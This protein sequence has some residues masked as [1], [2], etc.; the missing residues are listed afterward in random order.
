MPA[1]PAYATRT[2]SPCHPCQSQTYLTLFSLSPPH[3]TPYQILA[4]Q[5]ESSCA[6]NAIS[7]SGST[8]GRRNI[9][10]NSRT[11]GAPVTV[12]WIMVISC[13]FVG[14]CG[15]GALGALGALGN[16][17]V[18]GRLPTIGAGS[19]FSICR[20]CGA[21]FIEMMMTIFTAPLDFLSH[22]SASILSLRSDS[23][24]P[25]SKTIVGQSVL[26]GRKE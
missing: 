9:L 4:A 24:N 15:G 18:G 5:V 20:V 14:I 26:F 7:V 21:R 19:H 16:A 17:L 12:F 3:L 2:S 6:V 25:D 10:S 13:V 11:K 1:I 22:Q 8:A 23:D